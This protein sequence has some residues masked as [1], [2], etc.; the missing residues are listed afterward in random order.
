MRLIQETR[1][2]QRLSPQ[3]IQSL[4]LLQLP[5]LELER[6]LKQELE[7]NPLLEEIPTAEV[8]PEVAVREAT[9]DSAEQFDEQQWREVLA[10]SSDRSRG[11]RPDVSREFDELPRQAE[12]GLQEYLL[13][14]L[15]LSEL[16]ESQIPIGEEIIGNINEDGYLASTI[17]EIAGST[18]YSQVELEEVLAVIQT[19]DPTGVG[20]SDLGECLA[21]Q[22]REMGL[23]NTIYMAIVEEHLDD[24]QHHRYPVIAKALDIYESEVQE[25]VE[26]LSRLNPKPA[27]G[28]FGTAA[29]T[30]I[31][32]LIVEKVDGEYLV[33]F[34]DTSLPRLRISN[35][36]KEILAKES[37]AQEETRQYVLGK[38]NGARWLMRSIQQ[39]RSTMLKVMEYIVRAQYEFLEHGLR[40]LKPMT[41]Q[42]VADAIGMHVST[43]SRVTNGKY[44][45]TPQGVFELKYF[46]GGKI[47]NR[48]GGEISTKAI[49]E[50]IEQLV[51]DEDGL[52]PLSDQKIAEAL[53]SEGFEIA[54]RTVAKY[55]DKMGILP[56]RYRKQY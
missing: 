1:L 39:R 40:N 48:E 5:T 6:F 3:L 50:R 16:K 4:K 23:E 49:K 47:E 28:E 37:E 19:F 30:I 34:N 43:I 26:E 54:R 36:Y 45:Q 9:H 38:L 32:D 15:H 42:E 33:V 46:F 20:A 24:L 21:I 18:E 29:K 35:L 25:A 53:Q 10:D 56:A 27:A 11:F 41:L 2:E 44:V 55:R 17:E 52:K 22:L 13:G 31:P 51:N 14:Q 8:S 7:T 12:V